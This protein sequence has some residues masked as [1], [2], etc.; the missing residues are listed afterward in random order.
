[1]SADDERVGQGSG[2][3]CRTFFFPPLVEHDNGLYQPGKQAL[4]FFKAAVL[5]AAGIGVVAFG[6]MF[7]MGA[8]Y[9]GLAGLLGWRQWADRRT[10]GPAGRPL[11]RIGE[12]TA[13][14][15]L[16]SRLVPRQVEVT[17]REIK[18][19]TIHGDFTR[20]SFVFERRHG[21]STRFITTYGRHDERVIAFVQQRMPER[22]R[23]DVKEPPTVLGAV[24]GDEY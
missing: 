5:A 2:M 3:S 21:D 23:V 12:G 7:V 17:L 22:V 9:L 19:L 13:F 4:G 18:A 6:Q 15:S 10:F 1:L 20:R 11:V 14:F 8:V 24:R 16:P